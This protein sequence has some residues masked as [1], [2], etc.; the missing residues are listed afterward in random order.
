MYI[1]F[2]LLFAASAAAQ[3]SYVID[4]VCVGANRTYRIDGEKGSTYEW[5]LKDINENE[6]TLTNP[7]GTPFIDVI[8]PGDTVWG[9]ETDILWDVTGEFVLSTYQFSEH[10]CDTLEHGYVKVF[11]LPDADAGD[12]QVVCTDGVVN[13]TTDNAWNYSS[14]LWTTLG[15]G[16]FNFTDQLHPTYYPGYQDSIA[17]SVELVL[18]AN[19][20]ALNSTCTPAIDT[21]VIQIGSPQ[22]DLVSA[23][24]L[25]YNDNSGTI[26]VNIT[27]GFGPYSIAWT[28]PNGFTSSKDSIYNLAA[29]MY[30]VTITDDAGCEVTDSV[31][32]TEPEELLA[33]ILTNLTES[34]ANDTIWLDGNPSGGTG[35]YTHLWTGDGALYLNSTDTVKPTF[36]NAPP[37]TYTLEYTVTDENECTKTDIINL[38]VLPASNSESYMTL[39][40]GTEPFLWNNITVYAEHDSIYIDTLMNAAGCD[41]ILTLNVSVSPYTTSV[42]DMT[43]CEGTEPFLWNN[44]TVYAEHDSTYVDTLMNAAGC[45]SVLTLNV[46]VNLPT[47]SVNDTTLC[48][49]T[50]P[51]QWNNITIYSD[52]DD[53]YTD[54]LVNSVGCDSTLTLNVTII[55]PTESVI[56]TILCA[57]EDPFMWNNV[58]VYTD[59]SDTYTDKLINAQGCDSTL[60]LNVTIIQPTTTVLDTAVCAGEAPFLWNNITVYADYDSTYVDTLMN[61]LGC[62]SVI[63]LNVSVLP[64]TTSVTEMELCEGTEP[65]L[66]NNIT[67]Y[68]EHDSIY[69]DTLMNTAG[70]DS[71]LT[72]NVSVSPYTTSVTDMTLCEGTEPFLWNNITV[73]AEHD[74]TYVD[75][76]MNAAG[77]DSVL[78]LNVAVNLPTESVNDTTLCA[79][80]EP[81]QWNNI[82]IYSDHDDSYTD[83]LVNSVGCDSTLTLNVTIIQ[84]TE[85]VIDTILCAGEDPFMWNNVMVYTDQSDTYTDKLINAQG[86]D[87][88]L[89]LNVTIIQ[90]TTTVLDTAVCAGE[91]PFL[92]N[93]ITVYADYDSTY[94]DT[95]MNVL[96]CDSVINLNVSVLPPTTS[97][98]EM[99]LCEG[100]EPFQWNN[101][102]VYAEHD[103]I[104]VDTL[105]NAAGCDS[106]LTLNVSVSP[107]ISDTLQLTICENE[108]PYDWHGETFVSA[109]TLVQNIPSTNESCDTTRILQLE[110]LPLESDTLQMTVCE[111]ELPYIWHGYTFTTADTIVQNVPSTTGSCDT[112]RIL[113]LQTLPEIT[114]TFATTICENELPYIWYGQT[115]TSA[116]TIIQ[117]I[118]STTGGCDTTRILQLQTVPQITFTFAMTI[119]ENELPYTW[120]NHTFNSADT[121]IQ[122][123]PSTN[124]GCDT[125]RTLQLSTIPEVYADIFIS[126]SST[127]ISDGEQVTFTAFPENGGSNPVYTWFVN[128]IEIP[129]ETSDSFTYYPQDG[130]EIYATLT[131]DL[132]CAVP[133]PAVSN[134]I[135]ITY[136]QVSGIN[137]PPDYD[138]YKC[139]SEV[140]PIFTY[141]KEFTDAGGSA[142]SD[143]GIDTTTFSGVEISVVG[144]CP[145]YITRQYS[146][147]DSCG[148]EL[149]CTRVIRVN[150]DIAPEIVQT[151]D[152]VFVECY[153]DIP[154]PFQNYLSF[155]QAGGIVTDNCSVE[156]VY[157]GQSDPIGAGC[158]RTMIRTYRF[159][160]DCDN[161]VDYQQR[162]TM[163]DT[164]FPEI[165]RVPNDTTTICAR[166]TLNSYADFVRYGG[167][168][169]DNCAIDTITF[170]LIDQYDSGELI[171]PKTITNVYHLADYCGNA[172]EFIHIVHVSDTESPVMSAPPTQ[173]LAMN[174]TPQA[175]EDYMEFIAAGGRAT[176]NCAVNPNSFQLL[177]VDSTNQTCMDIYN[178]IYEVADYCGNIDTTMHTI[179]KADNEKPVMYMWPQ[180]ITVTCPE[181]V[182]SAFE[183][184]A[185]FEAAGGVVNDIMLDESSFEMISEIDTGST[186]PKNVVRTYQI[187]DFCGNTT[188]WTHTITISDEIPPEIICPPG[189]TFEC[190]SDLPAVYTNLTEFLAA[191]GS[192]NDNCAIDSSS[193]TLLTADTARTFNN[194]DVIRW[195][196]IEDYCGNL[197]YCSQ[198]MGINDTIP[199]DAVCNN[200]T[201]YLD[202]TGS[203]VLSDIEMSEISAGS[204]DN[205][206]LPEDLKVSTSIR[207]FD[208]TQIGDVQLVTVVVEDLAGN[209]STCSANVLVK[210]TIPP[211]ALCR[212]TVIYLDE[213]GTASIKINMIDNHSYDNCEIDT[214]YISRNNFTCED[215]GDNLVTLTVI[216][217]EA[218]VSECTAN[219][220]VIDQIAPTV[221]CKDITVQLDYQA[222]YKLEYN[223]VLVDGFDECG[224]DS[225]YLSQYEFSCDDIGTNQ[226]S[227][228]AVDVNGNE[229]SCIAEVTILG[230]I[231]PVAQN[232]TVYM[233]M[234]TSVDINVAQNDYDVDDNDVKSDI[235]TNSVSTTMVPKRGVAEVNAQTGIITYTPERNFSGQDVMVY[236]ICDDGIPC[237]PMCTKA[238]V[239]IYVLDANQPPIAENDE[240]TMTCYYL[241]DNLMQ[242]DHDPDS[243]IFYADTIPV[244]EPQNGSVIIQPN[245]TF[246]YI[247]ETNFFGVDS[248]IYRICD[249][250]IPPLCDEA[251]VYINVLEDTDCDGISD[252]DDIDDDNDGIL[253]VDEG[254]RTIDTDGDGIYDSLDIDSDNDGIPDNIEWQTEVNGGYI[255]PTGNDSNN[256]G[257]DD[258]YDTDSGGTYY[259]PVDTDE[260]TVPD[261]LDIDSDGDGVWDYIEGH[262]V[263]ADGIPD[264]VRV[265]ADSDND[266]LD[267]AYDTFDDNSQQP[268]SP[269]NEIGSNAP[270][271]D[272]DLDGIRD[273][274]DVNDDGD[275]FLTIDEDYNN[276]GDYSNDDMDL[277]GH[278]DYLDIDHDCELFIPEGFSPNDDGVHDF[279][280]IFCIQRYPK[281]K[282]M[283]FNRAG[284]KLFEKEHYGNMDYWGTDENAWWWGT[285]ENRWTLG[286]AVLPAG[287]YV[288]I[289]QL[290]NGETRTGTVMI[291]Y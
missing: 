88:T 25:C 156:L 134:I 8:T 263:N 161:Y 74:S 162:I 152:D 131:S 57:G 256:N 208:C 224:I 89:T 58:M 101:I 80:T 244:Q 215:T 99:E 286:N 227:L 91:A 97:V 52:H 291:S 280:Q 69:V 257:W 229:N 114:V 276:D 261:Y 269:D 98:T 198:S 144:N 246:T 170:S 174:E 73:Y 268:S 201:V 213:N 29:G 18:T 250:G 217:K 83:V 77:C 228:T 275:E 183:T 165:I 105:M 127:T 179:I 14:L 48:A 192:V 96:G 220:T 40:E 186:C 85:S 11:D 4:S 259:T 3:E 145:T 282:L 204:S 126:A 149:S 207:Q 281:A 90:P 193:F 176:D 79:G 45:D 139:L 111:T 33:D 107:Q 209:Q 87:S 171:C 206:T 42:T 60:T 184:L 24:L 59:Q 194:F 133:A 205:C 55:Q 178:Y 5:H 158:P 95:L 203:V 177:S 147:L 6:L 104:Y 211:T 249:I 185:D 76:L 63:N 125:L 15:D 12:D 135:T 247:P 197:S 120:Y 35:S 164:E 124:G 112:T 123:I 20:M 66:W 278:P 180:L 71:I 218:N 173:T 19:G 225:F 37:G 238:A 103:S 284:N 190:I 230:N 233:A 285:S 245:G 116:D 172:V 148:A 254:D 47:E 167:I 241:T 196:A 109:D 16:T 84:P 44:I 23:N 110:V 200:I 38:D 46:A 121:I 166:S 32:I 142:H 271:Q 150:D 65:F 262:D 28:G 265:Y 43:L 34:C 137:C 117:N 289:L 94:V 138:V 67:V 255:T 54:V 115:F 239:I 168:A 236:S 155:S 119:C 21:M 132:E 189:S 51:F 30:I 273:W 260:D 248:F 199:P 146:V 237:E 212:D 235:V 13:L 122:T 7:S 2:I 17:G 251:T 221:Y 106:I 153:D 27:E 64:P 39:C 223:Q 75:T 61:A 56:D 82:T 175:F 141:F 214:M 163:N 136:A 160:D 195:Y 267:D 270:L 113:Q 129:G 128:G 279:F 108:L 41:S 202:E 266:G 118:P 253:D 49:G 277:D 182:P 216:D 243:F 36:T 258:A 100:T 283:I 252:W 226:I 157:L 264:V 70:C 10:G 22:V 78:T 26:K 181:D 159:V 92:W 143:C 151:P 1:L 240:F 272:F 188:Q 93:N 140:H 102:T 232:D 187:K 288:Y 274:R 219:V 68:A 72:L 222:Y 210:D 191:G 53:S 31:E 234:N 130:D 231:A 287:N 9:S 290:G 242:N 81:F 169:T 50:E 154:D 86:C 62:D